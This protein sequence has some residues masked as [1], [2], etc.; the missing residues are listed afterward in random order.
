MTRNARLVA[1]TGLVL[2]LAVASAR[3]FASPVA[4]TAEELAL[5]KRFVAERLASV[6][7]AALPFSFVYGGKPSSELLAAWRRSENI[8]KLDPARTKRTI[9]F[10]DPQTGLALRCEAIEYHDFATV[11]RTHFLRKNGE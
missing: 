2:V 5:A 10:T 1:T 9:E 6:D 4:P 11:Q 7:R 3:A 8:E